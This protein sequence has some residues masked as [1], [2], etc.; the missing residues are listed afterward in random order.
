VH[1][2]CTY[3]CI[4]PFLKGM[5]LTIDSWRPGR[6]LEGWKS[7][8]TPFVTDED[9]ALEWNIVDSIDAP[10]FVTAVPCLHDDLA[11]LLHLFSPPHP[12]IRFV[13]SSKI[14]TATYGFGDASGEGFGSSFCLPDGTVIFRHGTWGR[15]ADSTTSNFRELHNLVL[16][17]E[18]GIWTGDLHRSEIFLFTDNTTAEG[19]F[20]KGNSSSWTLFHLILRLRLLEMTG[21]LRLHV[22][23]V[24]GTR[25][26]SQGTDGLSR[27]D[28]FGGVMARHPMLSFVPL[29]LD[30]IAR[31]PA[32]LE[33]VRSWSPDQTISP[34]APEEWF[35][36]GHGIIPPTSAAIDWTP[37][38]SPQRVY[39]WT[40]APAAA[41][42]AVDKLSLSRMKRTHLLHIW[43]CPR[44]CTHQWRKKLFKVADVVW[45]LPPGRR[46]EWPAPMHE[47]LILALVLPFICTSP[48]QLRSTPRVLELGGT[49]RRLWDLPGS[50]VG[51][52]LRQ[53]CDL[54]T[55][56][57]GLPPGVVRAMLHPAPLG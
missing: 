10:E 2:Q 12:P 17:L 33:W 46:P 3:P 55:S 27:G 6:D 39:L 49:V 35:T 44:L 32:L 24:A 34:L 1:L 45:E 5:H 8:P 56:L 50:D 7:G 25:M 28:F 51:S 31:T 19:G 43:L 16:A 48:W 42:V 26:I 22:L 23:H 13:R 52:V 37:L 9:M 4:T 54:P 11:C 15:D 18:D 53:L 36:S 21:H 47:T 40:P 14:V 20:Y 57:A 41:S 38:P 30:A 29:H